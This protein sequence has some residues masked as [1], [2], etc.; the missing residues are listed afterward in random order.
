M[1]K[2]RY[3]NPEQRPHSQLLSKIGNEAS[4]LIPDPFMYTPNVLLAFSFANF[5]MTRWKANISFLS[6]LS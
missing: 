6:L 5:E 4:V 1:Y 3:K 2:D